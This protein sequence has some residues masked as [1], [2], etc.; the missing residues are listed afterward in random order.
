LVSLAIERSTLWRPPLLAGGRRIRSA[1]LVWALAASVFVHAGVILVTRP[2]SP[3]A[4]I[5]SIAPRPLEVALAPAPEPLEP[6]ILTTTEPSPVVVREASPAAAAPRAAPRAR[7]VESPPAAKATTRGMAALDVTAEPLDDK[8]R[9]GSY[10]DRQIAEFRAEIDRPVRL[11][12]PIVAHYPREALR[13]GR[14]D[15]VAVWI[16]VDHTGQAEEVDVIDGSPE[17]A[18]EV[19][20]AISAAKFLPAEH[21]LRPIRFPIALE[22]RFRLTE[23]DAVA[24]ATGAR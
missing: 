23:A 14:E 8:V 5:A 22:F 10:V 2:G 21:K 11:D 3:V 24:Q 9:I 18:E 13:D 1:T 7:P 19:I 12:A 15:S 4:G 16:V 17:F 6:P 20:A